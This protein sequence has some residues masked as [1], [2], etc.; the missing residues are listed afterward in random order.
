MVD[1]EEKEILKQLA[2]L[3]GL[4]DFVY[5]SSGELAERIGVSQQTA[6]RKI[7]ELLDRGLITRRMGTR[8]QLI[9]LSP[10]GVEVLRKEHAEYKA[11]FQ[12]GE[13]V[14]FRG[15]VVTGLGEGQYYI[16]REGYRRAFQQILGFDPYPGTLN[17]EIDPIDREKMGELKE[18]EGLLIREFQSEGRTFGAVK[19]FRAEING[20]ECSVIMPVRSHHVNILE[21]IAPLR[22]R[23][24]LN[25][26]DGAEVAVQVVLT[27]APAPPPE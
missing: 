2:K 16:S 6:S 26:Q 20:V 15:R 5:T 23:D 17:V 8:K 14:T 7:L 11:I 25:L 18:A 27:A 10:T 13:R 4:H 9:R 24:K 21:L 22:L 3:G 12:G 19:C 1:P